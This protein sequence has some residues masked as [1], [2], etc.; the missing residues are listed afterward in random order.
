MKTVKLTPALLKRVIEE[1][2]A[3]FGDMESVEDRA[4]DAKETDAD[5]I[6]QSL[7]K[8]IDFAKAL[9]IEEGR[10]VKRLT[11]IRESRRRILG[12]IARGV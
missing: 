5:E 1:E 2:V 6:A 9:R 12:K 11:K 4:K 3:K 7:E 8:H 10:L